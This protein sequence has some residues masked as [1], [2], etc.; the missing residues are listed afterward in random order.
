MCPGS[1][2]FLPE[3]F[4]GH[5]YFHGRF[6][7]LK[8]THL[9]RSGVSSKQ[10]ATF[11]EESILHIAGGVI[12]REVERLKIIVI[13]FEMRSTSNLEPHP[14]KCPTYLSHRLVEDM[15]GSDPMS[16]TGQTGIKGGFLHSCRESIDCFRESAFEFGSQLV[17]KRTNL[18]ALAVRKVL[19][20]LEYLTERTFAT[21]ITNLEVFNGVERI[22]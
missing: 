11:D 10:S 21:Q 20:A 12:R 22:G 7:L 13:G 2:L 9:H 14:V 16:G 8:L 18:F 6:A 1:N 17:R 3:A 5:N 15:H 4:P 19:E